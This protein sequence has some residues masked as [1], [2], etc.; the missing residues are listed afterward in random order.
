[1]LQIW[2]RELLLWEY[3]PADDKET[4]QLMTSRT[5]LN[6]SLMVV[7]CLTSQII[8]SCHTI[9]IIKWAWWLLVVWCLFDTRHQQPSWWHKPVGIYQI[10]SIM[11]KA[12][13]FFHWWLWTVDYKCF[14][15]DNCVT[16]EPHCIHLSNSVSVNSYRYTFHQDISEEICLHNVM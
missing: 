15:K 4:G 11:T 2:C 12:E 5:L 6:A 7:A 9:V 8:C 10:Y 14:R 13:T 16:I 1:M 3:A